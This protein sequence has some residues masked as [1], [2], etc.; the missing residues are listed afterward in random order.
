MKR[1]SFIILIAI[2]L[3][4]LAAV[5]WILG[6]FRKPRAGKRSSRRRRMKPVT[7]G[8]PLPIAL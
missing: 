7:Q 5:G 2:V 6:L 3:L 8:A 1:A 4:T